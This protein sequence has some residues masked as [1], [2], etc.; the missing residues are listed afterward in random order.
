MP[1]LNGTSE[2]SALRSGC[3]RA[4]GAVAVRAV[5]GL[6]HET[7]DDAIERHVVVKAFARQLLQPLGV[8]RRDVGAQFYDDLAG[9][10]FEDQRVFRVGARRQ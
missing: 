10:S 3:F 2:N 9:R 5:A 8:A 7:V 6:R 1:R 4:A